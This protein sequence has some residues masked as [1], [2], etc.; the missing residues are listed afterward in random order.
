MTLDYADVIPQA[1]WAQA[2]FTAIHI[3]NRLPHTAFKFTKMLYG[4]MIGDS[5][6][7]KHLFPFVA[8]C[9]VH[10]PDEKQ[11]GKSKLSP[12][13]IKYY[14]V[15]YTESS[16]IL[17]L[18]DHQKRRVCTSKDLVF[19]DFTKHLDS[20][21]IELPADL[22]LDQDKDIPWTIAQKRDLW[23]WIV[24]N[25][26]NALA[27]AENAIPTIHKYIR[28]RPHE[29]NPNIGL[30]DKDQEPLDKS[31]IPDFLEKE[32]SQSPPPPPNRNGSSTNYKKPTVERPPIDI[33]RS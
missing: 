26:D 23:E 25:L 28:I 9:Y 13:R 17:C 22:P 21:E 3:K 4:I 5:P 33:D 12:R 27:R 1:L 29:D 10:V 15:G 7:I 11:I 30:S 16:K 20:T 6:S 24:K 2:C 8:K 18:Y 32:K 19:P 14:V 31:K